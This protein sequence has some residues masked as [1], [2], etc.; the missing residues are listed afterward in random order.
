MYPDVLDNQFHNEI[1]PMLTN[2]FIQIQIKREE[3]RSIILPLVELE[4]DHYQVNLLED[5]SNSNRQ[6][7]ENILPQTRSAS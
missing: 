2:P 7:E 5:C 1:V 4:V 3:N 6:I